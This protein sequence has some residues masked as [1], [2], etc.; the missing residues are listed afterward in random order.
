MRIEWMEK[1]MADAER[2]IYENQVEEGL[3]ILNNLLYEEPG[4]GSLHNHLGWAYMY[5]T[6]D[7]NRAE[8]HLKMAIRFSSQYA[9]PYLHLGMLYNRLTR[10]DEAITFLQKGLER[11]NANRVA[12]LEGIAQAYEMKGEFRS[13]IRAYKEAAL[14]SAVSFEVNNLMEGVKRCR[15]KRLAFLFNF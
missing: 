6:A 10:Y 1:Y 7:T 15:R 3:N 8:L 13:A 14:A 4:Y 11:P 2:L 12:M 5:Y 9:A